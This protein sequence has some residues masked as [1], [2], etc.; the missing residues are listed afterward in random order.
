MYRIKTDWTEMTW[1]EASEALSVEIP[2]DVREKMKGEV[3]EY[4]DWL[5]SKGVYDYARQV[6]GAL[7]DIPKS[8]RVSP[9]DCLFYFMYYHLRLIAD[10]LAASPMSYRPRYVRQVSFGGK[11]YKMPESLRIGDDMVP[12]S[13][14]TA[15]N[16]VEA[17]NILRQ[18][19]LLADKGVRHLNYF[20]AVYL[21][22]EEGY[23]E[24][25]IV[26]RAE[27]FKDM[28]MD[29]YWEVFFCIHRLSARR[30]ADTL[31]YLTAKR[32][33]LRWALRFGFLRWLNPVYWGH[34]IKSRRSRSGKCL[35]S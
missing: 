21:R 34:W 29:I 35:M 8:V 17:S 1:R 31:K 14:E 32:R 6:L 11:I 20:V 13:G 33:N 7:S 30:A 15:D 4:Q 2:S 9:E 24:Q 25:K 5:T 19:G 28:T 23:D 3:V 22:E 10:L 27:L 26:E 16:F 12:M 18:Y